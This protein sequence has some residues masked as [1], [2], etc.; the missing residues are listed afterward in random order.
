MKK[1]KFYLLS[2]LAPMLLLF[3]VSIICGYI[4]FGEYTFNKF[5]AFNEYPTFLVELGRMLREGS[6]IFYTLHAGMGVN[7]FSILNLYGGSPLNLFSIF[8]DNTTIYIFYTLLIYLKLGLAGLTMYIY[9]NSL[10][11]KYK[12]T[13]WNV[14]FGLIYATSGWAIAMSMHIMWLDAYILLPL[15]I[16]GLDKLILKG[17]Y[18]E[19]TLFLALAIII[20]YYTGFMLCIFMVIYFVYKTL[21]TNNFN[22]K[23]ILRFIIFSLLSALLSCVILIPTYFNLMTGR[24]SNLD[25]SFNY[26]TIDWFQILSSI[27]NMTIGSFITE[28]HFNYGST[29]LYFSIFGLVLL[30][31][32]F[33]N[34]NIHKKNKIIA[35]LI[36][37]FFHLSFSIPLIDYIWNLFQQPKWWEHRYQ[38]VYVFFTLILAYESFCK[39]DEIKISTK[40]RSIITIIFMILLIGSFS[41]KVLGLELS[42]LRVLILFISILFFFIYLNL[43]KQNKWIITL[44]I[45]ELS[46]NGYT[47]LYTNRGFKYD[48]ITSNNK[49]FN[50]ILTNIEE[51]YRLVDKS[52]P[53]AGLMFNFNS[54]QIFSS[55]YNM[56]VANFFEKLNM[57]IPSANTIMLKSYNPAV[58]SLLGLKYMITG[59]S[60]YFPCEN[61]L[62]TNPQALPLMYSVNKDILKI[63]MTNNA[64][65]NINNIYSVLLKEQVNLFYNSSITTHL[66]NIEIKEDLLVKKEDNAKIMVSTTVDK[67][68][69]IIPNNNTLLMEKDWGDTIIT[70]N[71]EP[72]ILSTQS[73][74]LI[75]LNK[76]DEITITYTYNEQAKLLE[77]L[78]EHLFTTLDLELYENS[79]KKI[80]ETTNYKNIE[81]NHYILK[82]EVEVNNDILLITIPYDDGLTIKVDGKE[83][84]YF[85]V[86]DTLIGIKVNHGKHLVEITYFPKGLKIG[87][88]ISIVSLCSL[89]IYTKIQNKKKKRS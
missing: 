71:K 15:I 57:I 13:I 6:S 7:F 60:N 77:S 50:Q 74:Y 46:I 10:N 5:D 27:Y 73:D 21:T 88:M 86:F 11:T 68:S 39:R 18:L 2:F 75:V 16:K 35:F 61:S 82:G 25:F 36:I 17:K 38:F 8:F 24:L 22:K 89:L 41:Y 69:L 29:T 84:E 78:E 51:D 48:E 67:K 85:K 37:L 62:C 12:D 1:K 59:D 79:I 76:G 54:I 56:K 66:E 40:I 4:P 58:L 3:V 52:Y 81:D 87:S 43:P 26:L 44:I 45:I 49:N 33:F 42:N 53:D 55:S 34:K 83:V 72:Y 70:I 47:T 28:D 14:V 9:L 23:T 30:I 32:Y 64:E 31:C 80:Q 20:N 19:Y 63:N 65:E